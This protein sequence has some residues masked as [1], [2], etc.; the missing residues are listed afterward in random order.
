MER[1]VAF[2]LET[3]ELAPPGRRLPRGITVAAAR[4]PGGDVRF[5]HGD[6]VARPGCTLSASECAAVVHDLQELV[7]LGYRLVTWNGLGF[8]FPML[9]QESGLVRECAE[10]AREHVDGMY[11]FFCDNGYPVG[12]EAVAGELG[13]SKRAGMKGADA[14]DAWARGEHE[15]VKAYLAGDVDMTALVAEVAYVD[16]SLAWR[17]RKGE[18]RVWRFDRLRTVKECEN[19]P[20][21]DTSWM[22]QPMSR[23]SFTAWMATAG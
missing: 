18:R 1:Y 19:V 21:P 22:T 15:R 13:Q 23:Q 10:L 16:G 6:V 5:W 3:A 12:L 8:D 20:V 7:R 17:T 11:A 4:M 9:A 2:D 14:P